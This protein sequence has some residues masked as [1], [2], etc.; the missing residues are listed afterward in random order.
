MLLQGAGTPGEG[1]C[2]R[3]LQHRHSRRLSRCSPRQR[4][5]STSSARV[6]FSCLKEN[7]LDFMEG[8]GKYF[9]TSSP[10][11]K[12]LRGPSPGRLCKQGRG[13]RTGGPLH[14]LHQLS[15]PA[16]HQMSN[17]TGSNK[18]VITSRHLP[19]WPRGGACLCFHPLCPEPCLITGLP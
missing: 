15:A 14:M 2:V 8:G 18:T 6:T 12:S 11:W 9:P 10:S 4:S 1:A 19:A 17:T 3:P 13:G 7:R 5:V 16:C